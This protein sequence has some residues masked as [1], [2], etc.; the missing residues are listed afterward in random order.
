MKLLH[1]P[2][3]RRHEKYV[4][5]E[6][7]AMELNCMISLSDSVESVKLRISTMKFCPVSNIHFTINGKEIPNRASLKDFLDMH[8]R[9]RL[10]WHSPIA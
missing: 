9:F 6:D 7:L 8:T 10:A 2:N 4:T 5:L 3:R 1:L